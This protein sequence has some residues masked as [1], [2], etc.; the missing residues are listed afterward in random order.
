MLQYFLGFHYILFPISDLESPSSG[1]LP[2]STLFLGQ[3]FLIAKTVR[4]NIIE[5]S[6][7][8]T[9]YCRITG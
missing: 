5:I 7:R 6:E 4:N 8:T 9:L 1:I 2:I 3:T